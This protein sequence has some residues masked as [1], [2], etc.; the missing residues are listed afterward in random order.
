MLNGF[1]PISKKSLPLALNGK[2]QTRWKRPKLHKTYTPVL[3]FISSFQCT[4][5]KKFLGLHST[6][7]YLKNDFRHK[8]S[9]VK[10]FTKNTSTHSQNSLSVTKFFISSDAP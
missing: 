7:I 3:H 2:Y 8:F 6:F 5:Y 4:S 9:F 1:C 10:G